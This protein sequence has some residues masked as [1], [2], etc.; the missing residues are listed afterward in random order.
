MLRSSI[1][2]LVVLTNLLF[3][4]SPS[5]SAA[6]DDLRLSLHAKKL[7]SD[8]NLFPDTGINIVRDANSSIQPSK[9]VEKRLIFPNVLGSDS[10]VSADDLGHYA[11]YYPIQHSHAA[12]FDTLILLDFISSL[13]SA[14]HVN[15]NR[16]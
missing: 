1:S 11:G 16:P 10:G 6:N 4:F 15:F 2:T 14:F 8:F 9:I 13:I 5:S 7:I 12:R 3:R